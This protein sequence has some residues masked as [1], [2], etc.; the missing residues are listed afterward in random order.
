MEAAPDSKVSAI[1][2]HHSLLT[3]AILS[4]V[5]CISRRTVRRWVR[6]GHFPNPAYLGPYG[7]PRWHPDDVIA[8]LRSSEVRERRSRIR[9]DKAERAGSS[10]DGR[11]KSLRGIAGTVS[12][13][14]VIP[15]APLPD[16]VRV[17]ILVKATP[18]PDS[19]NAA[20]D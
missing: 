9:K 6:S 14:V 3:A 4:S 11:P 16:G 15:D 19:R 5:L 1:R 7:A 13:G 17:E 8:Y 18:A 2:A 20:G 10:S 12:Q